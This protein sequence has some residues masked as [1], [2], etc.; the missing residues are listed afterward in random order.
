ML[1]VDNIPLVAMTE[2]HLRFGSS[3]WTDSRMCVYSYTRQV[4]DLNS[5]CGG[6]AL[7]ARRDDNSVVREVAVLR[8]YCSRLADV[9]WFRIRLG[10]AAVPLFVAVFYW[11]PVGSTW[12]VIWFT[13]SVRWRSCQ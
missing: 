12:G 6:V 8:D 5:K 10:D 13:R 11:P 2:T 9:A 4:V 7:A 3:Y 1:F